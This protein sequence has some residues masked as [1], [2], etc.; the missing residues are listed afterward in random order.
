LNINENKELYV[1]TEEIL[2][3]AL[4]FP[5]K[6]EAVMK[7]ERIYLKENHEYGGGLAF[8]ENIV[9]A[10]ILYYYRVSENL[11]GGDLEFVDK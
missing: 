5:G 7:A 11:I 4:I 9:V 6:L 1:P 3:H 10:V 2:K 8:Y